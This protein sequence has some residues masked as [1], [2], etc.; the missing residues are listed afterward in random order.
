MLWGYTELLDNYF[1]LKFIGNFDMVLLY[2][3]Q[4]IDFRYFS[5]GEKPKLYVGF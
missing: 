1:Q 5:Y 3:N 4:N 2:D